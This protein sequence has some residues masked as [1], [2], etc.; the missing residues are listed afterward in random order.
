MSNYIKIE[1][2]EWNDIRQRNHQMIIDLYENKI[3]LICPECKNT[4]Q[5]QPHKDVRNHPYKVQV[6]C[7]NPDCNYVDYRLE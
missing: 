6:V 5:D 1:V 7:Q 2:P 3:L 4:V